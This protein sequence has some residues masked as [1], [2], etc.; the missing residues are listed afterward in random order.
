MVILAIDSASIGPVSLNRVI[1]NNTVSYYWAVT[2]AV[3]TTSRGVC[4]FN[5]VTANNTL[6]YSCPTV[7]AADSA[8]TWGGPLS[9]NRVTSDNTVIYCR[10]AIHTVNAAATNA[11]AIGDGKASQCRV[12]R[13]TPTEIESTV[14]FCFGAPAVNY[15]MRDDGRIVRIYTPYG[16]R[17]SFEIDVAV[18][19]AGVSTVS[20]NYGIPV[21][22]VVDCRLNVVKIRGAIIID[23]DYPSQAWNCKKQTY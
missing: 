14:W 17:L 1:A 23:G 11:I 19:V 15:G 10:A 2:C 8:S 21:I 5:R 22:G 16:D 6:G 4:S 3:D 12:L 20:Y 13:L 7:R 9:F 18:A